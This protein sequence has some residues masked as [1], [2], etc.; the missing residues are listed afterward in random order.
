MDAGITWVGPTPELDSFNG[1]ESGG[2]AAR[3]GRR[4]SARPW[5][6]LA[7]DVSAEELA[8]TAAAVGYPLLVKA[9]AGG[10]GK[11]MRGR[12]T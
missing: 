10:G 2:E 9:S 11:G 6:E 8:S 4:S 1:V 5:C 7:A 12:G 3:R